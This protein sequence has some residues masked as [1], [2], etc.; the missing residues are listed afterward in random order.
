MFFTVSHLHHSLI[1]PGIAGAYHSDSTLGN[2][3][4]DFFIFCIARPKF[5]KLER[6]Q[7]DIE[8]FGIYINE[9]KNLQK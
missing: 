6:D 9:S 2:C 8:N 4:I 7:N 5:M 1:F 3:D